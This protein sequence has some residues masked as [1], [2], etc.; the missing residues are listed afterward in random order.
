MMIITSVIISPPLLF[1]PNT[2]R[3]EIAPA[4]LLRPIVSSHLPPLMRHSK[5]HTHIHTLSEHSDAANESSECECWTHFRFA[6][7][8]FHFRSRLRGLPSDEAV[9]V[10]EVVGQTPLLLHT[11]SADGHRAQSTSATAHSTLFRLRWD[12]REEAQGGG[13]AATKPEQ[14]IR[15][16]SDRPKESKCIRS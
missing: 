16:K 6:P 13:P 8:T 1:A 14:I 11:Q 4:L 10:E 9:A 2:D 3:K 7:S 15:V 5:K 12:T